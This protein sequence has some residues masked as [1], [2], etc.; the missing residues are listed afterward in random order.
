MLDLFYKGGPLMYP[1]LLG[2]ALMIAVIIE[3]A[4]HFIG[5]GERAKA[6]SA[7]MELV[8][9]G[10]YG[11]AGEI[12][13]RECSP[14]FLLV[15]EALEMRGRPKEQMENRLSLLGDGILRRLSKNLHLLELTGK[16]APMIGLLGTVLGMVEAF[17]KVSF[18][19]NIVNPSLLAS[20]IWEALIT[21]VSGLFVGIPALIAY[22]LYKNR[23]SA[24]AFSMKH[25][26]EE[27]LS[28]MESDSVTGKTGD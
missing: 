17:Q 20:G 10:S 26:C 8:R 3:R 2:S 21:T 25:H 24:V 6:F 23:V 19:K 11:K 9:A 27:L 18:M 22:H 5:T 12:A 28:M 13:E 15:Q 14:L 7:V 1:L 4:F 16:I